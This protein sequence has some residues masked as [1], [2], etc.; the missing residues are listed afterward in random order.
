MKNSLMKLNHVSTFSGEGHFESLYRRVNLRNHDFK[1]VAHAME[2]KDS[3]RSP[4]AQY[5]FPKFAPA[6]KRNWLQVRS[7]DRSVLSSGVFSSSAYRLHQVVIENQ[8]KELKITS[9]K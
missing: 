6:N 2:L 3:S 4:M 7:R 1:E 5:S 8:M 9:W